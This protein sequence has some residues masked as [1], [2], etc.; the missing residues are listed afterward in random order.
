[1]RVCGFM[2]ETLID[3][4]FFFENHVLN[5]PTNVLQWLHIIVEKFVES[6]YVLVHFSRR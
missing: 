1:M 6:L 5:G 2:E 3:K 4:C